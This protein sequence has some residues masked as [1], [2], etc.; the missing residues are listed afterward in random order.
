MA[1]TSPLIFNGPAHQAALAEARQLAHDFGADLDRVRLIVGQRV[2]FWQARAKAN[3]KC[4]ADLLALL[5]CRAVLD[6]IAEANPV[7]GDEVAWLSCT[8]RRGLA[9][10]D[11][12]S[13]ISLTAASRSPLAADHPY[14]FS[15]CRI[16][17]INGLFR[18]GEAGKAA[19]RRATAR[20]SSS[21]ARRAA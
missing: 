7:E 16:L 20:K 17:R 12:E 10:I 8:E 2:A 3:P 14:L 19:K 9:A 11:K 18:M 15:A 4:G 13:A 1:D 6:L 21:Q 5:A